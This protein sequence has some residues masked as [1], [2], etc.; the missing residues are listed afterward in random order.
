[1]AVATDTDN[2]LVHKTITG[3][4]WSTAERLV[5]LVL[6]FAVNLVL[7]R[8]L[9][10][11]DFGYIAVLAV[12]MAVSRVMIDGGFASALI[13]KKEPSKADYSAI[14]IWN[15]GISILFYLVLYVTAPAISSLYHLPL[16]TEVIRIYG[17]SL[18]FAALS[19]VQIIRLRKLLHF[20]KIAI[21]NLLS[22]ILAGATAILLATKGMGVWALVTVEMGNALFMALFYNI[23]E[24]WKPALGFD[25]NSFTALFRYGGYLL[26]ANILQEIAKNIQGML[27]GW[28]FSDIQ[29]GLYS[30]AHKL[31][32]I[33]SYALPQALVQVLFPVY[34]SIQDNPAKMAATLGQ[35][36]RVTAFSIFPLLAL[37]I[38]VADPLVYMLWGEKW[39]GCVP[40]FR[41][42]T[43]GGYFVAL[44]NIN[45]YAVAARGKSRTL[46][47]WSFYKW[48]VLLGLMIA[49]SFF[50]VDA[51][52]WAMAISNANICFVNIYLA[53][54]HCH[55]GVKPQLQILLPILILTALSASLTWGILQFVPIGTF[56]VI[57][58]A[59]AAPV[60]A[61]IYICGAHLSKMKGLTQT[62][63]MLS[64]LR[65]KS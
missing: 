8:L 27:I 52:M 36:V 28:K 53:G 41:I 48:G 39:L 31:D 18:I 43:V 55:L 11:A 58:I 13:Q 20:R 46:F 59:I 6:Q 61:T 26:G 19:Q 62:V 14:F 56:S 16:L 29:A 38:I 51:I 40:Y 50:S 3:T 12:F 23:F 25:R 15:L 64:H 2:S 44:Q 65:K 42:L 63:R 7:A 9:V 22:Y 33:N 24:R 34:S 35:S 47:Y 37:L 30:Q 5:T 57:R 10:P 21:I 1:M 17:L 4:V 60:F 54:K 49:A 32:Q 45:F